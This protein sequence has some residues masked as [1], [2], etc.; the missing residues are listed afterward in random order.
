MYEICPRGGAAAADSSAD[1]LLSRKRRC[2]RCT[3]T[4]N[5]ICEILIL[6]MWSTRWFRPPWVMCPLWVSHPGELSLPS[7]QGR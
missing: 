7:V 3:G 6:I 1:D 5:S 4:H 2:G